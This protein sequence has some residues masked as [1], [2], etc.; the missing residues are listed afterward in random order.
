VC[1]NAAEHISG[2]VEASQH[3]VVAEIELLHLRVRRHIVRVATLVTLGLEPNDLFLSIL[4]I[5][6]TSECQKQFAPTEG[7]RLSG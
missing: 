5:K 2:V 1:G 4:A 7:M 3:E 6:S